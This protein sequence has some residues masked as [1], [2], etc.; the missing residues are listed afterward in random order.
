MGGGVSETRPATRQQALNPLT[1]QVQSVTPNQTDPPAA[2][3]RVIKPLCSFRFVTLSQENIY[4]ILNRRGRLLEFKSDVCP[5]VLRKL[6][7]GEPL[8]SSC[9]VR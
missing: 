9:A 4:L 1:Q 8:V 5:G 7:L 6:I 2:H 3:V